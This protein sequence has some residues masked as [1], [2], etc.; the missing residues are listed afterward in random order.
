MVATRSPS[1]SIECSPGRS[2]DTW[3]ASHTRP[4]ATNPAPVVKGLSGNISSRFAISP[5][6][7]SQRFGVASGVPS[8]GAATST[9]RPG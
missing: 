2:P 5:T 4:L 3:L 9:T 6:V 7:S 1:A 8:L